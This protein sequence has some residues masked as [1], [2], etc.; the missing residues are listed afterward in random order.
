MRNQEKRE[1]I[2]IFGDG[3]KN[4]VAGELCGI[5]QK[6]MPRSAS[7]YKIRVPG[8]S[9]LGDVTLAVNANTSANAN[10]AYLRPGN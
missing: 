3:D 6:L 10:N 4:T 8:N 2:Y 5:A 7:L 9:F 1:Q